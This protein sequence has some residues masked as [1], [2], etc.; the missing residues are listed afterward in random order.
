[1]LFFALQVAK[2]YWGQNTAQA[3]CVLKY[4]WCH[5]NDASFTEI[6]AHAHLNFLRNAF[7]GCFLFRKLARV[8]PFKNLSVEQPPYLLVV[9]SQL[10]VWLISTVVVVCLTMMMQ[11]PDGESDSPFIFICQHPRQL[12]VKLPVRGKQKI[13]ECMLTG[14]KDERIWIEN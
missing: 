13:C 9:C 10:E 5:S 2:E 8:T 1:M 4:S 11:Y 6:S 12:T 3:D 7:F 14:S